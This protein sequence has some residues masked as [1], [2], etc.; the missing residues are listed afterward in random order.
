MTGAQVFL[1]SFSSNGSIITAVL[2][3]EWD[4]VIGDFLRVF[5]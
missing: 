5:L 4:P 3:Q 2:I 1:V